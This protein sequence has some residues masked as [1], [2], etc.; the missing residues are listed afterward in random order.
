MFRWALIKRLFVKRLTRLALKRDYNVE[1]MKA[2]IRDVCCSI[3]EHQAN[4]VLNA[5]ASYID[6]YRLRG[7]EL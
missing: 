2:L 4:N 3:P 1:Y 5:N 7:Q 6:S